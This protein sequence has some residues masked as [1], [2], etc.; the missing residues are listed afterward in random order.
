MK[1]MLAM[2]AVLGVLVVP[3]L[4]GAAMERQLPPEAMWTPTPPTPPL[5]AVEQPRTVSTPQ[6]QT[7]V[8]SR[9]S[10]VPEKTGYLGNWDPNVAAGD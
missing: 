2:L 4:V 3:V 9:A 5:V 7:D 6:E 8:R 1:R 10:V